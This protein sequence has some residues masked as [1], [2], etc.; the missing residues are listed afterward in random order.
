MIKMDD[1]FFKT[2]TQKL[3]VT[4]IR[5]GIPHPDVEDAVQDVL[6]E[7]VL[8]GYQDIYDETLGAVST[9]VYGF[10]RTRFLAICRKSL[11]LRGLV[12]IDSYENWD[13][14]DTP[15]D[16]IAQEQFGVLLE[17]VDDLPQRGTRNYGR[18]VRDLLGQYQEIGRA[19]LSELARK[20]GI[21][22]TAISNHMRSLR[23]VVAENAPLFEL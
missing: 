22:P 15:I 9:F 3:A 19:N 11:R 23:A 16:E 13:I 5:A 4:A 21:S 17:L 14:A 10:A 7:F 12:E 6:V 1:A 2:W 20:Y 18:L 8:K